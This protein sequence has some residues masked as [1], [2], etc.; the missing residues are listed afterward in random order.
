M[1][2]TSG[3]K[4]LSGR[5]VLVALVVLLGGSLAVIDAGRPVKATSGATGSPYEVP[6]AVD[7]NPHPNILETTIVADDTDGVD[8]GN[9]ELANVMTFN[10]SIPGPE[11]RAA[12]GDTLI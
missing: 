4:R 7:E 5:R 3:A 2:A 9:G 8:I 1:A 12:Q 6:T 11:L 10:G